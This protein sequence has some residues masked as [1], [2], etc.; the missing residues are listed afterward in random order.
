MTRAVVWIVVLCFSCGFIG[1][2]ALLSKKGTLQHG[3]SLLMANE[4][5]H[6][7]NKNVDDGETP[8]IGALEH[9]LDMLTGMKRRLREEQT[10]DEGSNLGRAKRCKKERVKKEKAVKE[11]TDEISSLVDDHKYMELIKSIGAATK[12]AMKHYDAANERAK[13]VSPNRRDGEASRGRIERQDSGK[14]GKEQHYGRP[15]EN[16]CKQG[17]FAIRGKASE[18]VQGRLE[19]DRRG[20][21]GRVKGGIEEGRPSLQQ[22]PNRTRFSRTHDEGRVE[23]SRRSQPSLQADEEQARHVHPSPPRIVRH[24]EG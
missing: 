7:E 18:P 9:V 23:G 21:R 24:C 22:I 4:A 1:G 5:Q 14:A 16:V 6:E 19:N 11:A 3:A 17:W 2:S 8:S 20:R 15:P 13:A 12:V 10:A